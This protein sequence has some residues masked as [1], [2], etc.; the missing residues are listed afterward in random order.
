MW[1]QLY[2]CNNRQLKQRRRRR[3]RE[4]QKSNRFRLAKQQLCTCITLFCTFFCRHCTTTTWKCL[5]SRFVEVVNTRQRSTFFSFQFPDLWYI[6]L[7]QLQ[8]NNDTVNIWRIERA[9]INAIKFEAARFYFFE[10]RFRSHRRRC[11]LSSLI[12]TV[13]THLSWTEGISS[14]RWDPCGSSQ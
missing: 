12:S 11:C 1:I 10:W 9:G 5:I 2:T 14:C 8:K 7:F 13:R 4:R 3:Q 6:L